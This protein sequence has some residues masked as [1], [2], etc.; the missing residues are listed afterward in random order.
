MTQDNLIKEVK[1]AI[2]WL[3]EVAEINR[4]DLKHGLV[5]RAKRLSD[6]IDED[7]DERF[8]DL[9]Y[10]PINKDMGRVIKASS[11]DEIWKRP[12]AWQNIRGK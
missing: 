6:A 5:D 11:K 1:N 2:T 9:L 7:I 8:K 4:T 12:N 3:C 10:R